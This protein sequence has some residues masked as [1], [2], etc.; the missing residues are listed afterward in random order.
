VSINGLVCYICMNHS[1]HSAGTFKEPLLSSDGKTCL[2]VIA[3]DDTKWTADRVILATGAWSPSLIDLE[4]QCTSKCWI[5]GHLQL[6]PEE[7]APLKGIPVVYHDE[8]VRSF[9]FHSIYLIHRPL[10]VSSLNHIWTLASSRYATSSPG[11]HDIGR[12]L[13]LALMLVHKKS[14]CH[15]PMQYTLQIPC[16]LKA[17]HT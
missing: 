11:I 13:R 12:L 5:I 14:R 1:I 9:P 4:G 15:D 17:R 16:L 8:I 3:E 6:T 7:A 2:G 10:R